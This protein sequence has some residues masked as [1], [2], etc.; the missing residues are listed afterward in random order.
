M[1]VAILVR[2]G[3]GVEEDKDEDEDEEEDEEDDELRALVS[4]LLSE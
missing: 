2:C 1:A 3:V 4:C